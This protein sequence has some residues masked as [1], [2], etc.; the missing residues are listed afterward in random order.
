MV[1]IDESIFLVLI[2][3]ILQYDAQDKN[4]IHGRA[5][6]GSLLRLYKD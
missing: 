4:G 2:N 6:I 5:V 3:S 1:Q